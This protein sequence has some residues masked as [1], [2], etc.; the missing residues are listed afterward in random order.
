MDLTLERPSD[1]DDLLRIVR[2]KEANRLLLRAR[3]NVVGLD[4][5]FRTR[6]GEVTQERVVKV[7]V[8]RKIDASFLGKE[9]LIPSTVSI[10]GREIGVDVEQRA[11][12]RPGVNFTLR[13]R[14]LRGGMSISTTNDLSG[15]G[16]LGICVTLND[17]NAYILSNNHVLASVNQAQPNTPIVQPSMTGDGG[18]S[19]D[20][21]VALLSSFVPLDFG[22]T[23][24]TP[25]PGL[26]PIQ[27]PNTNFVRR[28]IST[29]RGLWIHSATAIR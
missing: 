19:P 26:P 16:T 17:G 9:Q 28:S 15:T 8:S 29:N 7:Y 6:Q 5:G 11:I 14:P 21:I 20:D 27:I 10:D 13:D 18:V 23:T 3:P 24:I 2:A 12:P 25:L 1:K 4:V 22:F